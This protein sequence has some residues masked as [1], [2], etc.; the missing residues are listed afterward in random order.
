MKL[1]WLTISSFII[2]ISTNISAQILSDP[3]NLTSKRGNNYSD[4][5]YTVTGSISG[6]VWG[7]NPY[8]TDDSHC[9]TTAIHAGYLTN[10]EKKIVKYKILPGQDSYVSSTANGITSTSWGAYSGSYQVVSSRLL[11]TPATQASNVNFSDIQATQMQINWT[12]GVGEYCAVFVKQ[13]NT[14]TA[15][16]N[17]YTTYTANN[18]F[19]G[20]SQIGLTGWYCVYAGTGSS[21]IVTN[22][23]SSLDYII[24]VIEYNYQTTYETYN[25]NTS[26][27]NPKVQTAGTYTAPTTQASAIIFAAIEPR[28]MTINWTNGNGSKRIVFL[29][30]GNTGN[31]TPN[32]NTTYTANA[33]FISGT[34]IGS[35]GWYCVYNGTGSSVTI[36]GLNSATSYIANVIE[37]NGI[38]GSEKYLTSSASNN[39]NTQT[40]TKN[41]INNS[42][43]SL[44]IY[45]GNNNIDYEFTVTGS[46]TGSIWGDNP[47]YTDDSYC[48]VT[49]VHSGYLLNNEKKVV[50]FKILPGQSSYPSITRNSITSTIFGVWSGSFQVVSSYSLESPTKQAASVTFSNIATNQMQVNWERGNGDYVAVFM[51]QG[52]SGSAAPENYTLYTANNSFNSGTQIGS[53]G[54]YCVY[55]GTGTS[56][57]V[58]NLLSETQYIVH[59]IEYNYQ[60]AYETY[61]VGTSI[62]NPYVESPLPVELVSLEV[63]SKNNSVSLFWQTAAEINVCGFEIEKTSNNSILQ[64]GERCW[65]KI[66]FV[67]GFGNSNSYK[68]YTFNDEN[69]NSGIYFYRIKIVDNDGNYTYSPE[70]EIEINKPDNYELKQNYPNS[71]NPSTKIEYQLPNNANVELTLYSITGEFITTLLNEQKESGYYSYLFDAGKINNGLASGIYFYQIKARD[72]VTNKTFVQT[73]KMLLVK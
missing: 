57:T 6:G 18:S 68:N 15:L 35:T 9:A 25:T 36:T 73:K 52:N 50:R 21:V 26:I 67:Q 27:D 40:T 46:T 31:A 38:S 19:S 11:E 32:D 69:I 64:N 60:S 22:L 55:K 42:P 51:K 43:I 49:A 62:N 20:G 58:S 28:Q 54:W 29:K 66:G 17:N 45:R 10:G 44:V 37:Y 53:S 1:F 71:F 33:S 23:Q 7:T 16:P 65:I 13:G 72:N 48:S 70:A 59:A 3:G 34:Q 2:L 4:F 39:P 8:Y 47:Y 5:E 30:Q 41:T 61:N 14:G 24:H 63:K 12:R 56:V